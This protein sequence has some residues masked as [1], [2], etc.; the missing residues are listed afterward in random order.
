[1]DIFANQTGTMPPANSTQYTIAQLNAMS[2]QQLSVIHGQALAAASVATQAL[3][4]GTSLPSAGNLPPQVLPSAGNLP[5][6]IATVSAQ[7]YVLNVLTIMYNKK[8][9]CTAPPVSSGKVDVF[10]NATN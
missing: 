5:T 10:G 9:C 6:A 1:M 8:C 7:Q 2:C 4:T 3:S